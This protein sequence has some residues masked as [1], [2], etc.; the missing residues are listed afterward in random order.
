MLCDT[1]CLDNEEKEGDNLIS[2]C[3][4][5]LKI[6]ATNVQNFFLCQK[7]AKDK[8][9]RMKLEEERYQENFIYYVD[10]SYDLTPINERKVIRQLHHDFNEQTSNRQTSSQENSFRTTFSEHNNDLGSTIVCNFSRNKEDKHYSN[11]QFP[12]HIPQQ[13]KHYYG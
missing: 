10:T 12:L 7:C 11:H 4:I 2:N 8:A 6:L 9:L 1:T 3:L 13:I 5:K